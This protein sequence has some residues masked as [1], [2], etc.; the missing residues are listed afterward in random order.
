MSVLCWRKVTIAI[1][2]QE[3]PSRHCSAMKFLS[4]FE[5]GSKTCKPQSIGEDTLCLGER[6]KIIPL[7]IEE[8]RESIPYHQKKVWI[9]E[10]AQPLRFREIIFFK[11]CFPLPAQQIQ[12]QL[13]RTQLSLMQLNCQESKSA[14]ETVC[15]KKQSKL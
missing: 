4:H 10:K 12:K 3:A 2:R 5:K 6:L 9:S 1:K 15:S 7:F 14:T 11:S 8:R 13:S